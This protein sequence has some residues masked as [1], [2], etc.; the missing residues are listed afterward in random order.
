[1]EQ[2]PPPPRFHAKFTRRFIELDDEAVTVITDIEDEDQHNHAT[3]ATTGFHTVLPLSVHGSGYQSMAMISNA[4]ASSA[5]ASRLTGSRRCVKVQQR[6]VDMELLCHYMAQK[7]CAAAGKKY[8]FCNDYDVEMVDF[9]PDSGEVVCAAVVLVL[10]TVVTKRVSQ[11]QRYSISSLHRHQYQASFRFSWNVDTAQCSVIDSEPLTDLSHASNAIAANAAAAAAAG[12]VWH[13]AK[14]VAAVMKQAC[15][16]PTAPSFALPTS[17]P[18]SV[19]CLSNEAVIRGASLK[20]IVDSEHLVA[21]IQDNLDC[22]R[23]L[24]LRSDSANS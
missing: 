21:I 22:A 14:G 10:A 24:D 16:G 23:Q 6:S 3:M 9:D 19:K 18:G 4:K 15:Y 7:L 2:P 5:K 8:W 20:S 12:G 13:P 11:H 17:G 1:M